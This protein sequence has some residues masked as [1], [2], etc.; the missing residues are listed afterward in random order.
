MVIFDIGLGFGVGCLL[1]KVEK[2]ESFGLA[3][4]AAGMGVAPAGLIFLNLY[5]D[6]DL[7]YLI[8]KEAVPLWF[9]GIF[10]CLII[11]AA[12][13]G[14]WLQSRWRSTF[15]LFCVVYGLYCCWSVTRIGV[16]TSYAQYHA[17]ERPEFPMQFI[18]DLASFAPLTIGILAACLWS[19]TR[20]ADSTKQVA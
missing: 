12:L 9:P 4:I 15:S 11:G 6:W 2:R 1:K 20:T 14:N 17:G 13:A 7:Q 8:P 18:V 5:P 19:A 10:S 16:V 3:A